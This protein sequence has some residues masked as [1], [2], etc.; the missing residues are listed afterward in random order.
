MNSRQGWSPLRPVG[1]VLL[2]WPQQWEGC[3]LAWVPWFAEASA[4]TLCSPSQ[5]V[6]LCTRPC[7]LSFVRGHRSYGVG[8][9][10]SPESPHCN[11]TLSKDPVSRWGTVTGLGIRPPKRFWGHHNSARKRDSVHGWTVLPKEGQPEQADNKGVCVAWAG[12]QASCR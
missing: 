5:G 11:V 12:I 4:Q 3:W 7:P 9:H 1:E 8:A 10:P 2:A 6:S